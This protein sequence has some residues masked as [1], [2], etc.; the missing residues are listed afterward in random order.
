MEGQH[1]QR[2][3]CPRASSYEGIQGVR[4]SDVNFRKTH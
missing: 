3:E 1:E 4:E 2:T